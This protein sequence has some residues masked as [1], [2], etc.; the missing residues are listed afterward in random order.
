MRKLDVL[1]LVTLFATTCLS[2]AANPL[3]E[4]HWRNP[5]PNHGN[6][7][8]GIQFVNG[9]FRGMVAGTILSS[10][11]GTNYSTES[12][13]NPF[14]GRS[15]AYGNSIYVAVGVG[16]TPDGQGSFGVIATSPDGV[17]WNT[18]MPPN[19]VA[20]LFG[21]TYGGGVFVAVGPKSGAQGSVILTSAD[22]TSWVRT[23]ESS[24]ISNDWQWV[25]Y[26]NGMFVVVGMNLEEQGDAPILISTDGS[27]WNSQVSHTHEPF[28]SVVYGNE[29]FVAVGTSVAISSDGTTWTNQSL[30]LSLALEA[31][32]Y[33]GGRFVAVGYN[34]LI[35]SSTDGLIWSKSQSGTVNHLFG[36]AYGDGRFVASGFGTLLASEDGIQWTAVANA[37][38]PRTLADVAYGKGVFVAVGQQGATWISHNAGQWTPGNAGTTNDLSRIAFGNNIF[39]ATGASGTIVSST[40]GTDW[41]SSQSSTSADIGGIAYGN[42]TFVARAGVGVFLSSTDGILWRAMD[43][44]NTNASGGE[45][46]YGN[47]IFVALGAGPGA[48]FTSLDGMNWSAGGAGSMSSLLG[49]AYGNGVFVGIGHGFTQVS[50]NGFDWDGP[51]FT[52]NAWNYASRVVYGG[53][54]FLTASQ[55]GAILSSTNGVQWETRNSGTAVSLNSAAYG[56]GSFVAVGLWGTI[57][58]S[59]QLE[60]PGLELGPIVG[61]PN[62]AYAISISGSVGQTWQVQSSLDL[63]NWSPLATFVSTNS[64]MRF[65]DY[66]ATNYE[67]RFYRAMGQ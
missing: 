14:A 60:S 1:V 8:S 50:S 20:G 39:V 59:G 31:V 56:R 61:L 10:P 55:F 11:D 2:V 54:T 15:I 36:V 48:V 35:L 4:W 9:S 32:T 5:V 45:I 18:Q 38:T 6:L 34:G 29:T 30:G 22:G 52:S 3:D 28:N 7:F 25:T 19:N 47:G 46:E 57:L 42:G 62:G 58:Q 27:H 67:R 12:T 24:G 16:R 51:W 66:E 65:V 17:T 43:T 41:V 33:G 53:G 64:V 13:G 37:G 21:V 26:G 44:G 23:A 49:L 40:N 63:A